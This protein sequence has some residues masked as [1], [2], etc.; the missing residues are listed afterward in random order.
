[1]QA[2]LKDGREGKCTDSFY[3]VFPE[4]EMGGR[5]FVIEAYSQ[6]GAT[7]TVSDLAHFI[8]TRV[9]ELAQAI[10]TNNQLV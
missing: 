9:Y 5:D 7:F 8:N 10:K 3:D 2:F 6:R 1:M 4:L